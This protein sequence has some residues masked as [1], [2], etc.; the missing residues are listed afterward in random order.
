MTR[1]ARAGR[2]IAAALLTG[3]SGGVAA[4]GPLSYEG[5]Q[6]WEVC[7]LCHGYEGRSPRSKFPRLA[8]QKPDYIIKQLK[9]FAA[10]RREN[11]GGQM[12]AIVTEVAP[13]DYEAIADWFAG[14]APAAPD[15]PEGDAALGAT[16]YK[17]K[18]CGVCHDAAG[19]PHRPLIP[20][21]SAQHERYLAKQLR[22]YR[23]GLRANDLDGSMR[24]NSKRLSDVEIAALAAYLAAQPRR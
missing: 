23:D 19:P 7:G 10:G 5:T 13:E 16:L 24:R 9:D 12:V 17:K 18:S 21:V 1:R 3:V 4:A 22:D 8:G 2:A 20:H 6:P 15:E 11:D 14:Q